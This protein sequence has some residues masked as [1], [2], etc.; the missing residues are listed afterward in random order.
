M[1]VL[2]EQRHWTKEGQEP[3]VGMGVE[4]DG[5]GSEGW[6]FFLNMLK[7]EKTFRSR[8]LN[9]K[10]LACDVFTRKPRNVKDLP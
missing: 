9:L 7:P 4:G 10:N 8:C 3:G 6:L 1:L 5:I 2:N